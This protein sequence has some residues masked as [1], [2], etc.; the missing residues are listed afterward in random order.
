MATALRSWPA[1]LVVLL[2]AVVGLGVPAAAELRV[3]ERDP[4]TARQAAGRV[5]ARAEYRRPAPSLLQRARSW[6][7]RQLERLVGAV[8]G[9]GRGRVVFWAVAAAGLIA[10][11][12][13]LARFGRGVTA[14]ASRRPST[15]AAGRRTAAEWRAQAEAHDA[16]GRWRAGLRCRY[17]ALVAEL[18]ER[19]L[20]DDV[21]GRTAGEYR[22]E[23]GDR[24][25]AVS[26]PFAGATELFERAWYGNRPTGA[27]EA[28]RFDE[29]AGRVLTGAG[30]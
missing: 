3:P 16:T 19:G 5:L 7:V 24:A 26:E 12:V 28:A 10:T 23:V 27:D 15:A 9:G 2:A 30:R 11:V 4:A 20:V 18:A 1:R 8:F 14:D 25:P 29:L 21:P 13:V 17:R 22:Q 6:A